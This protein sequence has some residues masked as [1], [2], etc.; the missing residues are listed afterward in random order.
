[1]RIWLPAALLTFRHIGAGD[2]AVDNR[3]PQGL[4]LENRK[5]CPNKP[6]HFTIQLPKMIATVI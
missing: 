3:N 6:S 2:G 1:M 4:H 5:F